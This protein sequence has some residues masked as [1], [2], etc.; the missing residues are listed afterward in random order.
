MQSGLVGVEAEGTGCVVGRGAGEG[1]GV[2]LFAEDVKS[3]VER[4]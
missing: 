1:M 4:L 2:V 3:V